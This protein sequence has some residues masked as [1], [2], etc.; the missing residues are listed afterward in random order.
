MCL[1]STKV[2]RMCATCG[3]AF[4][5]KPSRVKAGRGRY[6]S[7][8]C[9]HADRS[10]RPDIPIVC[11]TCGKRFLACPYLVHGRLPQYCSRKCSDARWGTP[12]FRFWSHVTK[13]ESCWLW[14]GFIGPGGYGAIRANG[15][16]RTAHRLSWE[17]NR[18]PIPRG[19]C[20]L[21]N[22]PGGDTRHCVNPD[23]LWLGT[24]GD[25]NRDKQQ[26]GRCPCGD[27]NGA[28]LHPE[29]RPRGTSH[30]SAKLLEADVLAIRK[31]YSTG[32]M[33][34]REIAAQYGVSRATIQLIVTRKTWGHI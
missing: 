23:H 5:A 13:T 16:T 18:G 29:R 17:I 26:K 25:N 11:G 9:S 19:L 10:V 1:K 22:C 30:G 8:A 28:R 7:R 15:R 32:T 27:Q 3:A 20:V 24:H 2:P 14:T 12:E 6:C 34:Q 31:L 4:T 21:H 33:L